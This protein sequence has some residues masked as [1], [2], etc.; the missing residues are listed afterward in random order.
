MVG[1]GERAVAGGPDDRA[2]GRPAPG[3]LDVRR[4]EQDLLAPV[5]VAPERKVA[6]A[7]RPPLT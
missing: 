4:A 5:G 2:P 1:A 3:V 7:A 6:P